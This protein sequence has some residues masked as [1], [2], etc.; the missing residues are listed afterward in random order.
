MPH[1]LP[2]RRLV[3]AELDA[4][5]RRAARRRVWRRLV[6]RIG[7]ASGLDTARARVLPRRAEDRLASPR[8]DRRFP[9]RSFERSPFPAG[10]AEGGRGTP[11]Q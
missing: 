10:R 3:L 5:I 7:T 2:T 11:P 1:A 9:L 6:V 4:T 8:D